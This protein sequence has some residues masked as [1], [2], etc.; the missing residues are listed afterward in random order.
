VRK[1][2]GKKGKIRAIQAGKAK[3]EETQMSYIQGT[4]RRQETMF[5]AVIDDYLEANNPV[6]AIGAFLDY[7][8]FQLLGFERAQPARTG[9]PGYDPRVMLGIY[10]WGHL[11]NIRSTRRLE[12]ECQRNLELIW[13]TGHLVPDFK[14]IA[15]FRKDN[16]EALQ[17]VMVQFGVWCDGEELF[18][19]ELV[20]IDG[21]KFK[22]VNS[23]DRNFTQPKLKKVM[24]KCQGKVEQYL[25]ELAEMDQQEEAEAEYQLTVEELQK[26][27]EGLKEHVQKYEE[28]QKELDKSGDTQISL[29]DPE[30]RLMRGGKGT[31]VSYNL[32]TSVDDKHKLIV[33]TVVTN[34]CADQGQLTEIAKK[35]KALL[36]IG[37]TE[38]LEVVADGGYFDGP[39]LQACEEAKI[40]TYVPVDLPEKKGIFQTNEFA[41][42]EAQDRYRCPAGEYLTFL[43]E[44]S[45][46]RQPKQRYREYGTP[47]CG[48]CALRAQCTKAKTKGRQI[49]RWVGQP[50]FERQRQRNL[51]RRKM[52][53]LRSLLIEHV[54]GT[55]KRGMGFTYFLT[56][57]KEKVATEASLMGLSYNFKRVIGILGVE[58][59]MSS[60]ARAAQG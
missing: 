43:R 60:F 56:K 47:A 59:M 29:T 4:A 40:V 42:E 6:R 44:F 21:S 5:P 20:A 18:G 9:R 24:E 36:G 58:R 10:L 13:L 35:T 49:E 48:N 55:I 31:D 19:K 53:R 41:Y 28:L 27:I 7:L 26:K 22:A 25:L 23:M 14:T 51:L 52:Q 34:A 37:E 57:G 46:K 3:S 8:N 39:S 38:T 17:K 15:N 12:R 54:F 30:S 1:R 50:V 16:G 33:T 2:S 32:Q 11:N 45:R